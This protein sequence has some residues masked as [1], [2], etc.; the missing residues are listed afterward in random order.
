MPVLTHEET[1]EFFEIMN[2]ER[3]KASIIF[4][5]KTEIAMHRAIQF[6]YAGGKP[7]HCTAGD[8]LITVQPDGN[9]VPCRRMPIRV[10]NLMDTPLAELYEKSDLFRELRNGISEGCSNCFYSKLCRGGLRCLSYAMTGDPF[11]ADPSCWYASG[12]AGT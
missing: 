6:L 11:K 9:L 4:S 3:K 12:A 8:T 10:G 1:R 5:G 7:Y 2:R